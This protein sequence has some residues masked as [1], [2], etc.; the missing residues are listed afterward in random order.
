MP[1]GRLPPVDDEGL[2]DDAFQARRAIVRL[3]PAADLLPVVLAAA[4][5]GPALI[6]TPAHA[7]AQELRRRL[8]ACGVPAAVVPR[9]WPQAAAGAPVVL[10]A[11][12]AAWAPCPALA[13]IVVLD[14]HDEALQQQQAPTWNAWVVAAERARR[15]RVPCVVVS[16]CPTVELLA[17]ARVRAP[18]RDVERAGWAPL[19]VV[20]QRR[21]DPGQG[22]YSPRLV[23]LLRGG[24]RVACV[25]NRTGRIRL[26]ACSACRELVRCERCG[27]TVSQTDRELVCARCLTVRPVVC[28]RCGSTR[29]KAL[30][31]GVSRAREE[32]EALALRPVDEVTAD[33]AEVPDAAVL[34]G[35]EAVLHRLA[36]A[37]GVAFLDFDQELLAPRYRAA[38]EA[39]GLLALASRMVGGRG[40]GGRVI[41]QT[42]VPGHEVLTS[43]VVADPEQVAQHEGA[44]RQELALPPAI[45][46]AV[47]S[48]QGSGEYVAAL[49]GVEVLGPDRGRWLVRGADH[50]TLS[51]AL[52]GVARPAGQRLRVEVDPLRL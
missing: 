45:A 23:G 46:L 15:A 44:I 52:A 9:E 4:A 27:A 42:R 6:V 43:A 13:S 10:G 30:R 24:G 40:R 41:V 36:E 17:W 2:L 37:D 33:T 29:L 47:V 1:A 35:T 51:A 20:D 5:R 8:V 26:L 3:P 48:G 12:G 34:V 50:E 38:E 32:L 39:L 31:I 49:A 7:M 25:L 28:L 16:S 11:R 19:E 18:S 22:L 14:G 21:A